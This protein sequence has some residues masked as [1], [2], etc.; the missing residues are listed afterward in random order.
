MQEC[1][2][3][4][5]GHS[6]CTSFNSVADDFELNRPGTTKRGQ[7]YWTGHT[8]RFGEGPYDV[9]LANTRGHSTYM[10]ERFMSQDR[11]KDSRTILM[12]E[13]CHHFGV[14]DHYHGLEDI[15]IR[16]DRYPICS[17]CGSDN[18]KR[19]GSCV[20]SGYRPLIDED[21]IFCDG[22]RNDLIAYFTN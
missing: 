5:N 9:N 19:P 3:D 22:C 14:F 17:I 10:I 16:C 18:E 21:S 12:H 20:M 6:K 1:L 7:V 15:T 11:E 2:S 13:L 8:V 4:S